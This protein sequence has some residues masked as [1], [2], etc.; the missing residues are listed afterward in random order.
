[1]KLQPL[2]WTACLC[3]CMA[4]CSPQ[5]NDSIIGKW[6]AADGG[7]NTVEFSKDGTVTFVMGAET[8]SGK[9]KLDKETILEIRWD[10]PIQREGGFREERAIGHVKVSN[11]EFTMMDPSGKPR[12][13]K[14]A[15]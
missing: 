8:I 3:L 9:Y 2:V 11:D 1:M 15:K 10:S 7:A 5:P 14:R 4:G 12:K 13:F 6:Q